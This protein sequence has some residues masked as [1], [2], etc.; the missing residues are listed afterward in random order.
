MS[1]R[2]GLWVEEA[3][4]DRFEALV[5][6]AR[7]HFGG[8]R[9]AQVGTDSKAEGI[10]GELF[11][12]IATRDDHDDGTMRAGVLP[13]KCECSSRTASCVTR[14][15]NLSTRMAGSGETLGLDHVGRDVAERG[16]PA[17]A[18]LFVPMH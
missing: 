11:A 12:A 7:E 8:H 14:D 13:E 16:T 10:D 17:A 9:L 2:S 18:H 6:S 4:R 3:A 5:D 15:D 1:Y